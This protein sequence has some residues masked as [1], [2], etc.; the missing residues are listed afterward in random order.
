MEQRHVSASHPH[1]D[2][3]I[4]ESISKLATYS[5]LILT[6]FLVIVFVLRLYIFEGFLMRRLYG[7]K[8]TD[9]TDET[10]RRGFV[11]H[12]VAGLIKII[13]LLT[14]AYPFVAVAFGTATMHSSF[15]GKG[16]ATMGDVLVVCPQLLI[17]MYVFELFYRP[18]ISPVSS[19]HHVGAIVIAQSAVAISLD[20]EHQ[21]DATIEFILCFVWG[22]LTAV[23]GIL[24]CTGEIALT[25]PLPGGF[26]VIAE[27]W[28][29]LAIILYRIYPDDHAFLVNVF[30]AACFTE[31][32]G[33]TIE[34][35]VVM[36]LFGGLWHRWTLPFKIITPILHVIFSV[37]QLWGAMIFRRMW[38]RQ[39]VF[40][41][42]QVIDEER[43]KAGGEEGQGEE[44]GRGTDA[45][46]N[47]KHV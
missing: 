45:L 4:N 37:A 23:D 42:A 28:P 20:F 32:A 39:E 19:L 36:W 3:L 38:K 47:T 8:Y 35:V 29:H 27:F 2:E 7:K 16:S 25:L 40:L 30:R 46:T 21:V 1:V 13:L 26:D 34:T 15:S 31:V 9:M 14:A 33:T 18:K 24:Y 10:V 11:N 17:T 41:K 5:G 22:E 6:M 43:M 12:H 44:L